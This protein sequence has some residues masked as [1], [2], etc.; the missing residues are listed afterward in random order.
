MSEAYNNNNTT[1]AAATSNN[2]DVLLLAVSMA[3][4]SPNSRSGTSS[5]ANSHMKTAVGPSMSAP[6]SISD[7]P[8]QH[9]NNTS[10][11]LPLVTPPTSIELLDGHAAAAD[12]P[13]FTEEPSSDMK[14]SFFTS[15]SSSSLP[16]PKMTNNPSM[17]FTN[18][19]LPIKKRFTNREGG[20]M[21]V[22]G[23]SF[24]TN[25]GSTTRLQ[26]NVA[27]AT[28][29]TTSTPSPPVNNNTKK[30]KK[31][32]RKP[33]CSH[34]S[35]PNR[36]MNRGVC[37]RHGARVRICSIP[38]CSKYAQKGGV[39]IRHGAKKE[40]KRCSVEGCNARA[41]AAGSSGRSSGER[42]SVCSRH[43]LTCY[44][45]GSAVVAPAA[46]VA[47]GGTREEARQDVNSG[48][49]ID[50]EDQHQKQQQRETF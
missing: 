14:R 35:C 29:Q 45:V 41:S 12:M 26:S 4:P 38:E 19:S 10:A 49:R 2:L 33:S 21:V 7:S 18:N 31:K 11:T 28:T 50:E 27:T 5:L 36:V 25:G 3:A 22:S 23:T 37:A 15:S 39:C 20:P 48:R 13:S 42:R 8:Q 9:A 43:A 34:P 44:S 24:A 32:Y 1:A 46:A 17:F 16:A 30:E 6:K 47:D 40:Y